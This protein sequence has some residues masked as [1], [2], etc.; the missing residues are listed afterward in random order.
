MLFTFEWNDW[1]HF[2][3]KCLVIWL[4]QLMMYTQ[5]RHYSSHMKFYEP[6]RFLNYRYDTRHYLIGYPRV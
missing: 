2:K 1:I 4:L 5:T 3:E 6:K